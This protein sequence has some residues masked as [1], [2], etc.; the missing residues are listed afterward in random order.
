MT[1]TQYGQVY[2]DKLNMQ[3]MTNDRLTLLKLLAVLSMLIDHYNKFINPDYSQVM[4]SVGR[5]ALPIFVLVMAFNLSRVETN[6][7]PS[8]ALRLTLFGL[9]A[10]PPYNA[11]GGTILRGWW[12]LNVLFLL[13][14]LVTVVYLLNVPIRRTWLR[15]ASRMLAALLFLLSGALVEFFWAGLGLGLTA[16]RLFILFSR[17]ENSQDSS[18]EFAFLALASAVFITLLCLVN[19][20]A[21]ALAAIFLVLAVLWLPVGKLPRGKWFFYGFYPAHLWALWLIKEYPA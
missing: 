15:Y 17:S 16:W 21:W 8:I 20:N 3:R 5:L 12:P 1:Q 9:M 14:S 2:T 19:G 6:K 7:M 13:A 18:G 4:F 10:I 11:M